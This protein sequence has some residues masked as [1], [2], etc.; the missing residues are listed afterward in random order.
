MAR[1]SLQFTAMSLTGAVLLSLSGAAQIKDSNSAKIEREIRFEVLSIRP[2]QLGSNLAGI[3]ST[4][5]PTPNGFR[6]TLTIWQFIQLAYAPEY[7]MVSG[8]RQTRNQPNWSGDLYDIDARVSNADLKAWQSQSS[9]HELLRAAARAALTERCKL[10]IHEQPSDAPIFELVV[11]KRGSRLNAAAPVAADLSGVKLPSGGVCAADR[12]KGSKTEVLRFHR[13]TTGDLI[14][15][16]SRLSP[17][18]PIRDRTG[19]T[20]RYDFSDRVNNY[21]IGHLGLQLKPGKESRP[22]LVIDHI[23]KPSPN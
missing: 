2:L 8:I 5:N 21:P 6:A 22:I 7:N 12:F 17:S 11:G 19:L 23:E 10:A 18:I 15:F 1:F 20:G 3:R 9:Q 14:W 4:V 13:A 16:L